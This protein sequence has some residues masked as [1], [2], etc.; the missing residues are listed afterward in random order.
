MSTEPIVRKLLR[1]RRIKDFEENL[2]FRTKILNNPAAVPIILAIMKSADQNLRGRAAFMLSLFDSRAL[3]PL[4]A[5]ARYGDPLWKSDCLS[6]A[7][8]I[9][10]NLNQRER[11]AALQNNQMMGYVKQLLQDKSVVPIIKGREPV[12]VAYYYRV[13]DLTFLLIK[14]LQNPRY[15]ETAFQNMRDEARDRVISRLRLGSG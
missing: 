2:M 9:R 4:L 1:D 3:I 11:T 13:C 14:Y 7:A 5:A 8:M 12:E 15:D 10:M 6:I